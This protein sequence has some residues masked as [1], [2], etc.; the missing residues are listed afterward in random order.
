MA[1]CFE[2]QDLLETRANRDSIENYGVLE[3][4]KLLKQACCSQEITTNVLAQYKIFKSRLMALLDDQE[5]PLLRNVEHLCYETHQCS[6]ECNVKHYKDCK[7]FQKLKEP[8]VIIS[9]KFYHL[10][11]REKNLYIGIEDF[12]HFFLRCATK[13]HAEVVAESMGN[14]VEMHSDKRRGLDISDVSWRLEF[15]G[16]VLLFTTPPDCESRLWIDTL[17]EDVDGTLLPEITNVNRS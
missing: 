16:M 17:E 5:N 14:Y 12:L 11:L 4:K 1:G 10:F 13:T 8:R 15:T 9:L 2:L 6:S 3:I 7:Q